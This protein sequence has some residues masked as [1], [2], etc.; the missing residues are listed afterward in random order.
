MTDSLDYDEIL[1]SSKSNTDDFPDAN[2]PA[3]A[4]ALDCDWVWRN[5][6][7]K[8]TRAKAGTA[9]R[10]ALWQSAKKDM[11]KFIALMARAM[12]LLDKAMSKE[13]DTDA[14]VAKERKSIAQ[15]KQILADAMEE[16]G[17]A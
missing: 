15:L 2:R 8:M 12:P 16:A 5:L 3:Y 17:L 4:W 14:I 11:D 6:G 9:A 1:D 13:V 7:G 10:W